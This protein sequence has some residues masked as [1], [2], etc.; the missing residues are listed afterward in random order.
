RLETEGVLEKVG[1][2]GFVVKTIDEKMVRSIY[3][4]R[5]AVE[6]YAAQVVAERA[7]SRVIDRLEGKMRKLGPTSNIQSAYEANRLAH[8]AIV[9]ATGN[10][11]MVELF[12]AIWGRSIALRIYA[13][14]WAAENEHRPVIDNHLEILQALRS[15]DGPRAAKVMIKHIR[16]G[17]DQ[18]IAVLAPRMRAKAK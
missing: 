3:Q 12:D 1:R 17:L 10:G 13:D 5:E 18:Q 16:E 14:L 6:G 9:E 15:G 2:K 8:R 11:Y 4:A 7:D